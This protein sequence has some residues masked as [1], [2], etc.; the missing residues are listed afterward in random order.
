[1]VL[2]GGWILDGGKKQG[3]EFHI[4]IHGAIGFYSEYRAENRF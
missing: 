3:S 4:P 1:M 2:L